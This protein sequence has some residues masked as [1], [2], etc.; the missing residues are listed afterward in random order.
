[1]WE[2]GHRD[3]PCGQLKARTIKMKR[4]IRSLATVIG[5]WLIA[6]FSIRVIPVAFLGV[7]RSKM[8]FDM[9]SVLA[10]VVVFVWVQV[11][12]WPYDPT[13]K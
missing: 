4:T 3:K 10:V 12:V 2:A 5:A 1:M 6:T 7:L 11:G 13:I 9:V 8:P